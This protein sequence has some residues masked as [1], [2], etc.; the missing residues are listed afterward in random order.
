MVQRQYFSGGVFFIKGDEVQK[1]YGGDFYKYILKESEKGKLPQLNYFFKPSLHEKQIMF[2]IDDFDHINQRSTMIE[3]NFLQQV[4]KLKLNII[5]VSNNSY[6]D[7]RFCLMR[8]VRLK[9]MTEL[10]INVLAYNVIEEWTPELLLD[11][12]ELKS[13]MKHKVTVRDLQTLVKKHRKNYPF[14]IPNAFRTWS[15]GS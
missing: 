13:K 9:S 5:L 6:F 15:D 1:K 4:A 14:S 2:V 10:E 3:E 8:N 12:Q 7:K 11:F